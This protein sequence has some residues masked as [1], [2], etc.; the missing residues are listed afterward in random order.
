MD[1]CTTKQDIIS[2]ISD[3]PMAFYWTTAFRVVAGY[4]CA[5][6]RKDPV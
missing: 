1:E 3:Y 5:V 2:S 6:D 4:R